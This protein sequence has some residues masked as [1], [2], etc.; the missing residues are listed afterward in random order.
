MSL[1]KAIM[2]RDS[3]VNLAKSFIQSINGET[4]GSSMYAFFSKTSRWER[5]VR[6]TGVSQSNPA[7]VTAPAHGFSQGE[8]VEISDVSGM[9]EISGWNR[10]PLVVDNPTEHDFELLGVDSRTFETYE[11]GGYVSVSLENDWPVVQDTEEDIRSS[12]REMIGAKRLDGRN[13]SFVARRYDWESDRSWDRHDGSDPDLWRKPYFCMNSFGEVHKCLWNANGSPSTVE[14]SGRSLVPVKSTDGYVWK[15]MYTVSP[16][17]LDRYGNAYWFP[18]KTLDGSDGSDQWDVQNTAIPGSVEA[19]VVEAAGESYSPDTCVVRVEG[20]GTG[21]TAEIERNDVD[22]NGGISEVRMVSRGSG[23]TWAEIVVED[24]SGGRGGRFRALVSPPG[25]H[26]SD[27]VKELSSFYVMISVD[28][29]GDE[30]GKLM[31]GNDFRKFGMIRSPL[32]WD[33]SRANAEAYDQRRRMSV[34]DVKGIFLPD[35]KVTGEV[36]GSVGV[37]ADVGLGFIDLVEVGGTFMVGESV[38]SEGSGLATVSS[39]ANPEL[40]P[41]S[42]EM[43]YLENRGA[44]TRME[45]QSERFKPVLVF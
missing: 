4:T 41:H 38:R 29:V 21:A 32:E 35:E 8:V 15:Y 10:T 37:V 1:N 14:P 33:G 11:S 2:T 16:Q 22:P 42:G 40:R 28:F 20:D 44:V 31:V 45:T 39:V 23:Y 17:D 34:A 7:V 3:R 6:I 12:W 13:V 24:S 25:G 43:I 30:G 36:S 9:V 5:R 27:P 18:V 19:I 26:G